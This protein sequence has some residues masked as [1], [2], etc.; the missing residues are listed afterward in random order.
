M[1]EQFTEAHDEF[2][3]II[4]GTSEKHPFI[5]T[6]AQ[7]QAALKDPLNQ[8][9]QAFYECPP[10]VRMGLRMQMIEAAASGRDYGV[11]P[12]VRLSTKAVTGKIIDNAPSAQMG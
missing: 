3:A 12:T 2:T 4:Q 9:T 10:E 7:M 11:K 6:G 8:M 5:Q 1:R